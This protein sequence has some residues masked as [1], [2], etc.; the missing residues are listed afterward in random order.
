MAEF[1]KRLRFDLTDALARDVELLAHFFERVVRRHF[2][3][4]A[5]AS[6]SSTLPTLPAPDVR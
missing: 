4:E 6:V 1:A 5:H 3:A 2:N